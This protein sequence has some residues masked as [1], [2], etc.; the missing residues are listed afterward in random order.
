MILYINN[1]MGNVV[2]V[3]NNDGENSQMFSLGNYHTVATPKT[4]FIGKEVNFSGTGGQNISFSGIE[5]IITFDSG[6]KVI[7][8][9]Q[10]IFNNGVKFND[11]NNITIGKTQLFENGLI[12]SELIPPV[13]MNEPN[14]EVDKLTVKSNGSTISG[15][16]GGLN[17][18]G[19]NNWIIGENS[20]GDLCFYNT[21]SGLDNA[22]NTPFFCISATGFLVKGTA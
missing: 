5:Q 12:N 10:P 21:T 17:V 2:P 22:I 19:V 15:P 8:N 20:F 6:T 16:Y 9:T 4:N 11:S 14:L 3:L 1:I 13:K 7:Y 18:K